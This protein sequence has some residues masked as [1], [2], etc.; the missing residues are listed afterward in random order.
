MSLRG[1]LLIAFTALVLVPIAL[2]AYG[3]RQEMLRQLTAQYERRLEMVRQIVTEDLVR[4]G[5]AIDGRLESLKSAL[6]Q[7]N[8]FRAALT[9]PGG[10]ARY[11]IDY[12]GRAMTLAALSMLLVV[13]AEDRI[14]SSGH[15]RNEHGRQVPRLAA[16]LARRPPVALVLAA[17]PD[18]DVLAI[19]RSTTVRIANRT[20]TLI[21]GTTVD[22]RFLDRLSRDEAVSVSLHVPPGHALQLP[23]PAESPAAD[24]QVVRTIPVP[25]I[26][27]E[28]GQ[29][30]DVADA[31]VA[32]AE[33]RATLDALLRR[34]DTW[35]ALTAGGT[36]VMALLLALWVSSR[37][38]RP[39]AALADKTAVLDLDRLDVEFDEGRDEV[40]RLSRVLADLTARLR[41]STARIREAER[42]ATVGDLARQINHDI[43]N[44]LIPLRNVMRHLTQVARDDPAAVASVLAERQ[45]TIDSS[46][47][48]LETLATNYERLSPSVS[49]RSCDINALVSEAIQGAREDAHVELRVR[50]APEAPRV[51]ADPVALRRV[52][53]NLLTNAVDSLDGRPG[54]VTVTTETLRHDSDSPQVRFTVADTGH[55]MT[56]E[57][58]AQIFNDFYTTKARGTGLGLSIVRRLVMDLHGSIRAESTPGA[59]TRMIVDMPMATDAAVSHAHARPSSPDAHAAASA[60]AHGRSRRR[61]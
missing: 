52:L 20:L 60:P 39:I 9:A 35:F 31:I 2:L 25:V 12:A 38:S 33:S 48:Y 3:L 27:S 6:L 4:E 18:R 26:H 37:I 47:A 23:A 43:K 42:R 51:M 56:P 61:W 22:E 11:V 44:G 17:G 5:A 21:G 8:E 32:V 15:F 57:Q 53:E 28:A 46:I 30:A 16:T 19:A 59:G 10:E 45:T 41:T 7:D 24:I 1:R 50:L 49:R 34:V 55:G 14:I 36:S 29:P 40:G 13:D 54:T 58:A